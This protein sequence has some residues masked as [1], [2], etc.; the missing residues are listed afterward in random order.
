MTKTIIALVKTPLR[1][2]L[3]TLAG[4]MLMVVLGL[5]IRGVVAMVSE[6]PPRPRFEH[7][8]Y[9]YHPQNDGFIA[10]FQV[11]HDLETGQEV[12]CARGGGGISVSCWPT[13]R[14]WK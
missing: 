8:M 11:W 9:E 3:T 6:N 4:I 2:L 10:A 13:G 5:A 14:S 7:V 1:A 12:V